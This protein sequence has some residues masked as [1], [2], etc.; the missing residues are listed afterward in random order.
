MVMPRSRSRSMSSRNCDDISR[1]DTV[2][3]R[4]RRRSASVDL[5]WSMCAM[6]EK[7]RMCAVSRGG[8]PGPASDGPYGRAAASAS[9]AAAGASAGAARAEELHRARQTVAQRHLGPPAEDLAGATDVDHAAALLAALRRPVT[10][11]GAAAGHLE[12]HG[13]QL[14]HVGLAPRADVHRP[15]GVALER[16]QAHARDIADV[17]VVAGLLAV[18]VHG[19]GLAAPHP[20]AE[21]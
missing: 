5:P 15:A 21:H 18:A 19:H 7:L 17:D 1:F 16:Q 12:H 6:I 10:D 13:G 9:T 14:V 3:V 2:P 4:S 20:G 8:L 11:L